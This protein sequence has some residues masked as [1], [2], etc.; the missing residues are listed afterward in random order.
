MALREERRQKDERWYVPQPK[1]DRNLTPLFPGAVFGLFLIVC[2]LGWSIETDVIE[3]KRRLHHNLIKMAIGY[4]GIFYALI[5]FQ[6][7][8]QS[9]SL[10]TI[11]GSLIDLLFLSEKAFGRSKM[12][13]CKKT[14][15]PSL[16]I[17]SFYR[18]TSSIQPEKFFMW[19]AF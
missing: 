13:V 16:S 7:R 5:E 18:K 3:E 1:E 11:P 15:G 8:L 14:K 9:I 2:F 4:L 6:W 17:K 12:E 10:V 19:N